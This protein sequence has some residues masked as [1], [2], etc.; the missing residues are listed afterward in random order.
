MISK[1]ELLQL[2]AE[3][4]LDIGVIEKDY[5][6][7]WVLAAIAAEPALAEHWIFKGGTCLRKCYYETYRFS[8]DLDFT[9]VDDG[10]QEPA[11]LTAIFGRISA[12]LSDQA[13]IEL[14]VDD[15]SFTRRR[16]LRGRPTT[17][18]RITYSGP[19]PQPTLPKLKLDITS[20][21]V[22]V[23]RPVARKIVHTYSDGLPARGV[24]CYSLTELAAEKI[25]ASSSEGSNGPSGPVGIA[26]GIVKEASG[27]SLAPP[28]FSATTR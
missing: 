1:Q 8:E 19:N 21:E 25:R 24:R 6:L 7:G 23:E 12:W 27:P 28:A 16:N 26:G 9:V 22:L 3:W 17:Q 14:S 4:E 11:E 5:V 13:G 2:R 15:G 20:D 18:G 10:P